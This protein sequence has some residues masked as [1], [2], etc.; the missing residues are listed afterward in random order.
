MIKVPNPNN[1]DCK[2]EGP[3]EVIRVGFNENYLI[4]KSG[5]TQRVH[6]NRIRPLSI[7]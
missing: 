7:K 6:A 3:S 1:L 4:K 5:K 2:W